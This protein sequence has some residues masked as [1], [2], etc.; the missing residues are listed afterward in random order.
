[1]VLALASPGAGLGLGSLFGRRSGHGRLPWEGGWPGRVCT[2][3][4][5]STAVGRCRQEKSALNNQ[6]TS[7]A[8]LWHGEQKRREG[9]GRASV[10]GRR[11]GGTGTAGKHGSELQYRVQRHRGI[12]NDDSSCRYPAFVGGGSNESLLPE[13]IPRAYWWRQQRASA[14]VCSESLA[15]KAGQS[16]SAASDSALRATMTPTSSIS[17]PKSERSREMESGA[18]GKIWQTNLFWEHVGTVGYPGRPAGQ[19]LTAQI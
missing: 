1:M 19:A 3:P 7:Q 15:R 17:P 9:R 2:P 11:R 8:S 14:L 16:F 12:A 5:C 13:S 18:R 10:P 6:I 4:R